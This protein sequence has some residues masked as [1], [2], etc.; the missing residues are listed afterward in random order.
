MTIR[1]GM[2]LIIGGLYSLSEV[3]SRSG[4]P[5]LADIPVLRFL[6]S[7]KRKTKVKSEL[8]FFITPHI[9]RQRLSKSIFVPPGEKRR[10]ERL[11]GKKKKEGSTDK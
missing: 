8:D 4:V 6:F 1:D 5:I 2:T 3:E 10:L 9:L 7:R 11:K